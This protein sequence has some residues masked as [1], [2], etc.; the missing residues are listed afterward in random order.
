L[1]PSVIPNLDELVIEDGAPVDG[2]LTEKEMRLLT[3]TLYTSWAG[4]G[5]G[6]PFAVLANVGLFHASTEPPLVP[7]VMLSLDVSWPQDLSVRANLSYFV[8]LRGKGPEVVIEIVSNREGG[9]DTRKLQEYARVR[10]PYYVIFDPDDLLGG[11]RLR[12]Y[13]LNGT[14]YRLLPAPLWLEDVGLGLTLWDGIC[15]GMPGNWLRWCDHQGQVIPT[16]AERADQAEREA[17]RAKQTLE[18]LRA[19]LRS[20]GLE[21]PPADPGHP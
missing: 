13:K 15:E 1:D 20:M 14:T 6:R 19:H 17:E 12:V 7:D 10:I 5:P 11:G 16:G 4:P 8:W 9:E 18:Q 2:V 21:P 3:E